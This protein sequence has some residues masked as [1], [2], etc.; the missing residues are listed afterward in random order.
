MHNQSNLNCENAIKC[1]EKKLP[2]SKKRD[3][4]LKCLMFT[5]HSLWPWI[6]C[7][8]NIYCKNS[9]KRPGV[10][11]KQYLDNRR[12]WAFIG[13]YTVGQH[14]KNSCTVQPHYI[15]PFYNTV[16]NITR[17]CHGSQIVL[18]VNNLIITRFHL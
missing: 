18:I 15:T 1:A 4:L 2:S 7:R 12:G 11:S 17:P 5:W 6:E 13:G 8:K 9:I 3:I 10:Y 16:F 14:S